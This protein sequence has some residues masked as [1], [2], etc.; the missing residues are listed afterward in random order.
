MP[1]RKVGEVTIHWREAGTGERVLVLLHA[2]PLH[3]AMWEP[4]LAAL[5]NDGWRVIAPDARGFGGSTPAPSLLGME[6]IAEDTA[7]LLDGLGVKTAVVAGLS[8]GGYAAFELWRRRRDLF[9]ALVLADTKAGADDDKGKANRETL[10]KN[11]L[12]KGIGWVADEVA[13]KLAKRA[14]KTVKEIISTNA[15]AAVAAALRGMAQRADSKATLPSIDVPTLI[16]V[17]SEDGLTPPA[18]ARALH[19]AIR[20][21]SLVEIPGAGHLA[22]LDAPEEFTFALRSFLSRAS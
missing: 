12:E 8:M 15:P 3:S 17:G 11:A 19:D 4:Q 22:N 20:G 14:G 1:E 18:E 10:A 5:A 2:F 13:P 7:G 16:V 21:S 6:I 9:H